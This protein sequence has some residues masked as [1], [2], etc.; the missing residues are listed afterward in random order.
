MMNRR[1]LAAAV[2]AAALLGVPA[3]AA[4]SITLGSTDHTTVPDGVPGTMNERTVV[5][6][7]GAG[8]VVPDGNWV[9]VKVAAVMRSGQ[10]GTAAIRFARPQNGNYL[11]HAHRAAGPDRDDGADAVR[12]DRVLAAQAPG[13]RPDRDHVRR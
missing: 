8:Y 9:A 12:D 7:S 11:I 13:R 6:T 10:F 2:A 1:L 5:Q 3:S 4:A